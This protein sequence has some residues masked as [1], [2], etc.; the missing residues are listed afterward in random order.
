MRTNLILSLGLALAALPSLADESAVKV[1]YHGA[2][3]LQGGRVEASDALPGEGNAYKNNW[4]GQ[5]GGLLAIHTT[6][7]ENWDGSLGL[8]AVL[9]QLARGARAQANKWYTFWAPWVDEARLSYTHPMGEDRE[10]KLTLGSYHYGYNPDIKNFGQYLLHGYVYPGTIVTSLTGPLGVNQNLTGAMGSFKLGPISDDLIAN[11]ETE[12][13]PLYDI[14]IA[15]IVTWKLG[16]FAEVGAGVNFYRAIAANS[17]AT[18]PGK[19]CN[20]NL[21][22][23]YANRGQKNACY[24]LVDSIATD[25]LGNVV[26]RDTVTGSLSGTKL[27]GRFRVDPKAFFGYQDGIFGKNDFV[28][29]T[30]FALLGTKD[31]P[32]FYDKKSRRIPVMFGLNMP[33]FKYIDWSVEM[34]YYPSRNSGDNLAAESGSWLPTIDAVNTKRDDWKYSINVS[35]VLGGHAVL[36]GQVANDDLRLGGNHDDASGKLAMRTPKDWYWTTKIAY[37]F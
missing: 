1:D 18:S 3:W 37:F 22:G 34:E 4:V 6:I 33:G 10:F 28:F 11:I 8:G 15:D 31:Y 17:K 12:D 2:G 16:A 14:S 25:T 5:S 13:K 7:D 35:S 24:I 9:V 27:M 26:Y 20:Q 21:L 19:D 32:L 23:P 36:M 30:E 29:Y